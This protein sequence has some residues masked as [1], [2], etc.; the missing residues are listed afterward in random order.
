MTVLKEQ[1]SENYSFVDA[2]SEQIAGVVRNVSETF[3]VPCRY[4]AGVNH[5]SCPFIK[6][7]LFLFCAW[8]L[9]LISNLVPNSL[10]L[11]PEFSS[12]VTGDGP[13]R[14]D[15]DSKSTDESPTSDSESGSSDYR[16]PTPPKPR[17][18]SKRKYKNY[19]RKHRHKYPRRK[20]TDDAK[21]LH[22]D[23]NVRV[24][25]QEVKQ[26]EIPTSS[27]PNL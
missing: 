19:V 17:G 3:P 26:S 4:S 15:R 12:N 24:K 8:I 5:A 1:H 16:P 21:C 13:Q 6:L 20:P 18:M 14:E 11:G 10:Q 7:M 23:Q 9:I 27:T 22:D 25:M 2:N